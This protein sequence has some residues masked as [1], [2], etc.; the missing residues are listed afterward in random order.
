M[1]GVLISGVFNIFYPRI[2]RIVEL[3]IDR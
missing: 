1:T 3:L 2:K